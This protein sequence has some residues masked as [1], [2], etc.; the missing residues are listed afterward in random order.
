MHIS[1]DLFKEYQNHGVKSIQDFEYTEE[2]RDTNPCK[3]RGNQGGLN[4]VDH[5]EDWI[6]LK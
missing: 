6:Q 3:Y 5:P 2:Y 1:D 4:D